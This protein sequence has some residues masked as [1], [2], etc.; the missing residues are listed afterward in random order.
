M[1]EDPR[2]SDAATGL[3][4][5]EEVE[6][7]HAVVVVSWASSEGIVVSPL[8]SEMVPVRFLSVRG[9]ASSIEGDLKK[10]DWVQTHIAVPVEHALDVAAALAKGTTE[11]LG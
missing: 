6:P 8:T 3:P 10:P 9:L 1:A 11:E 7:E 4:P 2:I 5:L